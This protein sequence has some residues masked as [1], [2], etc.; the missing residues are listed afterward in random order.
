M[1]K[2]KDD[3]DRVARLQLEQSE[4]HSVLGVWAVKH[5]YVYRGFALEENVDGTLS[6]FVDVD[7]TYSFMP[8]AAVVEARKSEELKQKKM[9]LVEFGTTALDS[10][11]TLF[12]N[13]E[14][15]VTITVPE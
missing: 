1:K 15:K 10:L 11:D 3:K 14:G 13:L 2:I 12:D 7:P 6:V 8:P 9:S 5:G 4:L